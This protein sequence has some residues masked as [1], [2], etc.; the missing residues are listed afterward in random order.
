MFSG[1]MSS[2]IFLTIKE[3]EFRVTGSVQFE[4]KREV[5]RYLTT[6]QLKK[7]FMTTLLKLFKLTIGIQ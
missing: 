5:Y 6:R 3:K 7:T 2:F 4:V 1:S